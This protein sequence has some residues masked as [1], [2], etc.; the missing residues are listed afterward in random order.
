MCLSLFAHFGRGQT[1]TIAQVD[2]SNT[3]DFTQGPNLVC[4][5]NLEGVS[6]SLFYGSNFVF[7]NTVNNGISA[8]QPYVIPTT[9]DNLY[10]PI[11]CV[12][13]LMNGAPRFVSA[14]PYVLNGRFL[15]LHADKYT[16]A[17]AQ[18]VV[19][20]LNEPINKNCQY[21]LKFRYR[22]MAS[23]LCVGSSSTTSKF[24]YG[25]TNAP[26]G[27]FP[28]AHT[29][30]FFQTTGPS[31]SVIAN[32]GWETY[33]QTFTTTSNFNFFFLSITSNGPNLSD[34]NILFDDIEII[35]INA[36]PITILATQV[37]NPCNNTATITYTVSPSGSLIEGSTLILDNNLGT[38]ILQNG[39]YTY[40]QTV[41]VGAGMTIH[42]RFVPNCGIAA[43]VVNEINLTPQATQFSMT[44]TPQNPANIQSG[45]TIVYNVLINNPNANPL[46]I[47]NLSA[48]LSNGLHGLGFSQNN[49]TIP[50]FSSVTLQYY[51]YYSGGFCAG[52]GAVAITANT[53]CSN[54]QT[55]ITSQP[56]G[57]RAPNP[58]LTIINS[59]NT[60]ICEGINTPI[61]LQVCVQTDFDLGAAYLLRGN[62]HV[63]A[64][65]GSINST[66]DFQISTPTA[67]NGTCNGQI[68]DI[69]IQANP[70]STGVFLDFDY[71]LSDPNNCVV[72]NGNLTLNLP[73]ENCQPCVLPNTN[74]LP[75]IIVPRGIEHTLSSYLVSQNGLPPVF[76][77]NGNTVGVQGAGTPD[78]GIGLRGTCLRIGGRL[79]VDCNFGLVGVNLLMEPGAE[80]VV[81]RNAQFTIIDSRLEASC[82][83][84]W[85]GIT[86]LEKGYIHFHKNSTI[87]DAQF[88]M[89]LQNHSAPTQMLGTFSNNYIGVYVP[90]L[91]TGGYNNIEW[92]SENRFNGCVFTSNR[93]LFPR[94]PGQDNLILATNGNNNT[95][96]N[97]GR[98][99]RSFAGIH[100]NDLDQSIIGSSN[101]SNFS[102][103]F[104]NLRFGI[105]AN[106]S[107]IVVNQVQ[108]NNMIIDLNYDNNFFHSGTGI[109]LDGNGQFNRFDMTRSSIL[110]SDIGVLM[111]SPGT[112]TE[113]QGNRFNTNICG[114]FTSN[115][116]P[117]SFSANFGPINTSQM[118]NN[119]DGA[120]ENVGIS[121]VDLNQTTNVY[122]LSNLNIQSNNFTSH[123]TSAIEVF[124]R[125]NKLVIEGNNLLG[126]ANQNGVAGGRILLNS[127][128]LA[129]LSNNQ[130]VVSGSFPIGAIS[131][132]GC[133][134]T[135]LRDNTINNIPS[136]G[137]PQDLVGIQMTNSTGNWL[138]SN[139]I[140]STRVGVQ[141]L[142][143]CDVDPFN[144][145]DT[146]IIGTQFENN[147]TCLGF[148]M[149][150]STGPQRH[151]FNNYYINGATNGI[152]ADAGGSLNT[153]LLSPFILN[154]LP[155]P[156]SIFPSSGWFRYEPGTD[157][158]ECNSDEPINP[159]RAKWDIQPNDEWIANGGDNPKDAIAKGVLW[160]QQQNLYTR[161]AEHPELLGKNKIVDAFFVANQNSTLGVLYKIQLGIDNLY[162]PDEGMKIIY[163]QLDSSGNVLYKQIVKLDT[164]MYDRT[165]GTIIVSQAALRT[166]LVAQ[167]NVV[168]NKYNQMSS[169]LMV[170]MRKNA[171]HLLVQNAG[172]SGAKDYEVIEQTVNSIYLQ[173]MLSDSKVLTDAQK[174]TIRLA[175]SQCP[176]SG[177]RGVF[178]ARAL[179]HLFENVDYNN[180]DL[181]QPIKSSALVAKNQPAGNFIYPNPTDGNITV[182][183]KHPAKASTKFIISNIFG[184]VVYER[185]LEEGQTRFAFNLDDLGNGVFVCN[186]TH[187]FVNLY[188]QTLVITK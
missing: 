168:T 21:N 92:Q 79:I 184:Q 171:S 141:V 12:P 96:L 66:S 119:F 58:R 166:S 153:V 114:V 74:C 69:N 178:R 36:Q 41:N 59:N 54:S 149:D 122:G 98:E 25:F 179:Q 187:G 30:A 169:A 125:T 80:I 113:F 188:A 10:G 180:E 91:A 145:I 108:M 159:L 129:R 185:D 84:M 6:G 47:T 99:N 28:I 81:I 123:G 68:F 163:Q 120:P 134:R 172:I 152:N 118:R 97:S 86:V 71:S 162:F 45:P 164:T 63:N 26:I 182:I 109:K 158:I 18:G 147:L 14:A 95:M 148:T 115:R 130:L 143:A 110:G 151:L 31:T 49:P 87:S 75:S 167:L 121:L 51:F 127:S 62:I 40:S 139:R 20:K 29:G 4:G 160:S 46:T 35:K 173:Y 146:R 2:A 135:Q 136:N 156:S 183:I 138:C 90:A 44:V 9:N 102:T 111:N 175:A 150:G 55:I 106:R 33:N 132:E 176:I 42:T 131:L 140:S 155:P 32:N 13:A 142:G 61:R 16:G 107:N 174:K 50:P 105:I 34:A 48:V 57:F 1:A 65:G 161:L 165:T 104:N 100:V 43:T 64:T 128:Q 24:N 70:G 117:N 170:N 88:G 39:T 53:L 89:E 133:A 137:F 37:I 94:Y 177:G 3:T 56:L 76:Q 85:K 22:N 124:F 15:E 186:I 23:T 27:G 116:S 144:Q 154:T 93:Q 73:V 103:F 77:S 52:D 5:G 72:L 83:V 8:P 126:S 11:N 78:A 17:P 19:F 60:A 181:C 101:F 38:I 157:K 67:S 82:R 7:Y 112:I